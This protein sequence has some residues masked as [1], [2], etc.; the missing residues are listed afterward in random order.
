M[1][2]RR[3]FVRRTKRVKKM[4]PGRQTYYSFAAEKRAWKRTLHKLKNQPDL[5]PY[6][7]SENHCEGYVKKLVLEELAKEGV[8]YRHVPFIRHSEREYDCTVAPSR[9]NSCEV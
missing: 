4:K 3:R 2:S 8:N 6:Q 5:K 7:N 9:Q 1:R